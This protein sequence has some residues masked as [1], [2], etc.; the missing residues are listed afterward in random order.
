VDGGWRFGESS[1][2]NDRIDGNG[3][4]WPPKEKVRPADLRKLDEE[5][6]GMGGTGGILCCGRDGDEYERSAGVLLDTTFVP[7][8][9]PRSVDDGAV[10]ALLCLEESSE[11]VLVVLEEP[12]PLPR[13]GL[14]A[15]SSAKILSSSKLM[16]DMLVL[17]W[18]WVLAASRAPPS[19]GPA[20][21]TSERSSTRK[22]GSADG[23]V[24]SGPDLRLPSEMENLGIGAATPV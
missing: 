2:S 11:I 20:F 17:N 8:W 6:L 12:L 1:S 14:L 3:F 23:P 10:E 21:S 4:L 19:K 13:L 7:S 18:E 22:D 15:L 5:D 24:V 9:G 16:L